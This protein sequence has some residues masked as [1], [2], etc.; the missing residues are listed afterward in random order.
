MKTQRMLGA[1]LGVFCL[2]T[3][4]GR[5][6]IHA[7]VVTDAVILAVG[8]SYL[9]TAIRESK[10]QQFLQAAMI[11]VIGVAT[12]LTNSAG[13]FVSAFIFTCGFIAFFTYGFLEKHFWVKASLYAVFQF[14]MYSTVAD[15]FRVNGM[16]V[17]FSYFSTAFYYVCIMHLLEKAKRLDAIELEKAKEEKENAVEAGALLVEELKKRD[18]E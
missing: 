17:S 4:L 9:L 1:F 14:F 5:F 12:A 10:I 2:I 7:L 6:I 11:V 18:R 15:D 13:D 8:M 16:L 3:F